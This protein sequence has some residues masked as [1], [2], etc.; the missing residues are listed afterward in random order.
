MSR[1]T[2]IE[3]Q[4]ENINDFDGD[5]GTIYSKQIEKPANKGTHKQTQTNK[6]T[7]R[8]TDRNGE[9][10]KIINRTKKVIKRKK[11]KD[12]RTQ[13]RKSGKAKTGKIMTLT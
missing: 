9:M 11:K 2:K 5:G 7:D 10:A 13:K 3:K 12:T 1:Q 8:Q 6:H 4:R